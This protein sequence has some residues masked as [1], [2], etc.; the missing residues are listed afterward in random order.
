M[1]LIPE[2]GSSIKETDKEPWFGRI[3]AG[4]KANG[5]MTKE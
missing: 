1:P 5:K 2:S 3:R 4:L